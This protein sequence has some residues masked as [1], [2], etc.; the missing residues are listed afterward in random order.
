MGL[1][2]FSIDIK[3]LKDLRRHFGDGDRGGQAP[4]LRGKNASPLTVGLGPSHATRACE[5]VS[6]A[7]LRS[8]G[9]V[10]RAT[11]KNGTSSSAHSNDRGGQAPALR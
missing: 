2:R 10:P 4:A 3:D 7:M 8:R 5:R 1:T 6:L 11:E 9:P